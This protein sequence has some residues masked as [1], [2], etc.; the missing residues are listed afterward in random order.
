MIRVASEDIGNADPRALSLAIDSTAAYERLGSPEGELAIAQ[1]VIYL[2]CAAK[3]NAVYKAFKGAMND[4]ETQGTLDVPNHLKNA[5]TKLMK[6]MGYG[7]GY[8]YAHD[9]P[10]GYAENV[11]YLPDKLEGKLYYKPTNRGLEIQIDEK[12]RKLREK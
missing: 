9:E 10:N 2:A 4:A 5:P 8:R 7:S 11:C 3:S 12:L 1:A 6:N